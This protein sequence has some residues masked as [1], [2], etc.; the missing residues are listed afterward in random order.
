MARC[1]DRYNGYYTCN[2]AWSTWGRWLLFAIVVISFILFFFLFRYLS[3]SSSIRILLTHIQL[4]FS[5]PTSQEGSSTVLRY[6]MGWQHP[7]RPWRCHVQPSV[8]PA[9]PATTSIWIWQ[10]AESRIWSRGRILQSNPG[11]GWSKPRLLRWSANRSC[12]APAAT[13]YLPCRRSGLLASCRASTRQGRGCEMS[14]F[15]RRGQI[16]GGVS[17]RGASDMEGWRNIIRG[18]SANC[19]FLYLVMSS[20]YSYKT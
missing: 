20:P 5:P 11:S 6:W 2:R 15:G 19:V 4:S 18:I 3:S 10:P 14:G 17:W 8:R 12:R 16:E 9:E 7:R 1:Y 13:E